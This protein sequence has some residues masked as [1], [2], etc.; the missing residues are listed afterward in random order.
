MATAIR[1]PPILCGVWQVKKRTL[2]VLGVKQWINLE[3]STSMTA[4][5]TKGERRSNYSKSSINLNPSQS[6]RENTDIGETT[7]HL[8]KRACILETAL[9]HFIHR[10]FC[11]RFIGACRVCL[12]REHSSPPNAVLQKKRKHPHTHTPQLSHSLIGCSR[13]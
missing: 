9:P 11:R 3:Q 13:A 1:H 8:I 7:P 4:I 5:S 6:E 10:F 2:F 12:Y